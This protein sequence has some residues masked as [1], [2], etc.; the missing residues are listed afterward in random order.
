MVNK[1]TLKTVTVDHQ[2]RKAMTGIVD[3]QRRKAMTGI[4]SARKWMD[5]VEAANIDVERTRAMIQLR[6]AITY[7]KNRIA[8]VGS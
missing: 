5:K 2:R 6:R 4:V 3:H 8:E 7:T 1:V